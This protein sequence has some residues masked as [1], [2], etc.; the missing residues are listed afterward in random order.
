MRFAYFYFMADEPDRIRA[1]A[2][3]HAAYW[4]GL[5]LRECRGGPFVDRSGGLLTFEAE[6]TDEAQRLIAEDPFF[7]QALLRSRW[8]KEWILD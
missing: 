1:V 7:L 5:A 6:S 2:P 8:L 4:Q 3:Q